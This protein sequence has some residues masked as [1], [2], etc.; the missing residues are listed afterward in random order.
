MKIAYH[1]STSMKSDLQTDI[2]ASAK[3][4]YKAL[5]LKDHKIDAYLKDHSLHDIKSFMKSNHLAAASINSLEFIAFQGNTYSRVLDYCRKYSQIAS[6]I[7]C[8][9]IVV[10]PSPTPR[11]LDGEDILNYPWD[12]MVSEYVSIL[13][14]LSDIS[15]PY[16]VKLAFEFLGFG[17]CSVRTPRGAYTIVTQ[18]DRE[19]VGMNFDS[20]HF[21]AGGGSLDELN[22]V[23]PKKLF[24]F[25]INDLEDVAKEAITDSVR[26]LP[27]LGIIP[28]PAICEKLKEIGYNGICTVELFRPEYWGWDPYVLAQKCYESTVKVVS[29]YFDIE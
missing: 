14:E 10:V 23:N 27:G 24:T 8:S 5:E 6:E 20:C 4:G 3:A 29:P 11:V 13:Q 21:Y 12:R 25:H 22:I 9:T 16:G 17:W 18:T 2:L 7:E 1:G 19:N 26:L 15:S 28:L